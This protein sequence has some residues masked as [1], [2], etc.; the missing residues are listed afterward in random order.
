MAVLVFLYHN[1]PAQLNCD[2]LLRVIP[3]LPAGQKAG[4]FG[5]MARY[6]LPVSSDSAKKYIRLGLALSKKEK[7]KTLQGIMLGLKGDLEYQQHRYDTALRNY[8]TALHLFQQ[9]INDG[10]QDSTLISQTA[11][12]LYN[13]GVSSYLLTRYQESANYLIQA[14]HYFKRT[15]N[16]PKIAASCR[17][18]GIVYRKLNR[19]ED[20]L[21]FS[22]E[23][24]E[25]F[26][27]LHDTTGLGDTYNTIGNIFYFTDN[28]QKASDF[29]QKSLHIAQQMNNEDAIARAYT[30]L[31][32]VHWKIDQLQEAAN[33]Y[34][35]ALII[36]EKLGDKKS[37]CTVLHNIGTLYTK[38]KK[39]DVALLYYHKSLPMY[40]ENGEKWGIANNLNNIADALLYLEKPE[41]AW[42]Y[43]SDA[44]KIINGIEATDLLQLNYELQSRY[45]EATKNFKQALYFHQLSS[46]LKDTIFNQ[47]KSRQLTEISAKYETELKE[48]Q[49]KLLQT[50]KEAQE[51]KLKANAVLIRIQQVIAIAIILVAMASILAA[52]VFFK[53]RQKQRNIN[54]VLEQKNHEI[55]GQKNKIEAQA[56]QLEQ[57]AGELQKLSVVA[58]KTDNAIL[59][60]DRKGYF[61]WFNDG[62]TKLYGYTLKEFIDQKGIGILETSECQNIAE[63]FENCLKTTNSA[64][65]EAVAFHKNGQRLWV[66]TTLTPILD[67]MGKVIK[68]I[69]IDSD[70]TE[71]KQAG[72]AIRQQNEEIMAQRDELEL[73][74]KKIEL[75]NEDIKGSIR[76]ALTIQQAFLSIGNQV[77]NELAFFVLHKPKDIVSGDFYWFSE[78][79]NS[80]SGSKKMVIA[81]VDCTGHGV[82]GAFMSLLGNMMLNE[83]IDEKQEYS[84]ATILE[85]LH[86]GVFSALKQEH[87]ENHDGMDVCLV[88]IEK[89]S[90]LSTLLQNIL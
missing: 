6:Y 61:E 75:Q 62:F 82:P 13:C 38:L 16:Q 28:H 57:Y 7:L 39:Y 49:I 87:T 24:L 56:L 69:A 80:V 31:G 77:K 84:P 68:L 90:L 59:I 72:E 60:M 14:L 89:T 43:I 74:N 23:A 9:E 32:N 18:T 65:Y 42:K 27:N 54:K 85:M 36:R 53:G 25:V 52:W 26:E 41:E 79:A 45:H 86:A 1:L 46:K 51:A 30:N 47:E 20:A 3:S 33:Y 67:D 29:F 55:N 12:A 58:S 34:K 19:F 2:S 11:F 88:C 64:R 37:T 40:Y 73:Q 4:V 83:I 81:V 10:Q 50:E 70:I 76:Y 44:H 71:L 5:Q 78:I 21:R 17:F 66:Q 15:G 48:N 63:I 8:Q 35:K 22:F